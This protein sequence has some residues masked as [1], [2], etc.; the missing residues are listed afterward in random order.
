L[1][2]GQATF[3]HAANWENGQTGLYVLRPAPGSCTLRAGTQS[4]APLQSRLTSAVPPLESASPGEDGNAIDQAKRPRSAPPSHAL[5]AGRC[6]AND[7]DIHWGFM[8]TSHSDL[9]NSPKQELGNIEPVP[10]PVESHTVR[11]QAGHLASL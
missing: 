6:D 5:Q 3:L 10:P 11:A 1:T 4:R 8:S 9:V 2:I 7:F